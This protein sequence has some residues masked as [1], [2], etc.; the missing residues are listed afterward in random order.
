MDAISLSKPFHQIV[1]D[2]S[3]LCHNGYFD[4]ILSFRSRTFPKSSGRNRRLLHRSCISD[5]FLLEK[6]RLQAIEIRIMAAL[7]NFSDCHVWF[8]GLYLRVDSPR[9]QVV[10]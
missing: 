2:E 4:C 7:N 3:I 10:N 1:C 6:C 8:S 5:H 9:N